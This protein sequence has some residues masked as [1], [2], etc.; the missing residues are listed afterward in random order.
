MNYDKEPKGVF[1]M[2]DNKSFYASVE[3]VMR[4]LNPLKVVMVVISEQENTNG[5]LIL[6]T[7]PMAKKIFGLK[8]NVSRQR[9]LP[10][11]PRII[12]VPPRMNLYIKRN[13]QINEIFKQYVVEEDLYPYSIDE[14]ILDIT[15]TWKLF[16]ETP[17]EVAKKIQHKVRRQLGLYT[18]I[19]V[20]ENP[21]QAKLA[22][23]NFAKKSNDLIGT[24]TYNTV[25]QKVWM[26]PKLT[27]VWGIGR[28]TT[29][30]LQKLGI[31]NMNELAHSNP[32]FLKQEFGIIGTQL[33]A[34]AWGIDRTIL[35]ERVKPKEN[36]VGNSQVLPR[37]Y[38]QQCEIE[39]VIKEISEQ[40]AARLRHRCQQ[41]GELTLSIGFSY[42]S[43][44]NSGFSQ[45]LKVIP[46]NSNVEIFKYAKEIFQKYWKGQPVRN[47]AIFTAKLSYQIG[48]QLNLFEPFPRISKHQTD[49]L[50]DQIRA[51]YGFTAL[52]YARSLTKGGTAIQRA[53]LVGGHNGGNAYE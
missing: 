42:Q 23:D 47:I 22:L 40:V 16:G 4:G 15:K 12:M 46:T 3:A 19:G 7:S 33:F 9:D 18:T 50:V 32:Y 1:L 44:I 24:I 8:A 35:S 11:D 34:T 31:N 37:N 52:V 26:I 2:I 49:Q 38:Q 14:S 6:A 10:C 48:E 5:G 13:L 30:R 28:R 45:S 20:G 27:D 39:I 29:E 41:C 36:S 43:T 17:E 51:E 21:L 53:S 25:A